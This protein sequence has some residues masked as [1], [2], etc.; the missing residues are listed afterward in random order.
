MFNIT[1]E[2]TKVRNINV[3]IIKCIAVFLVVSVH[4]FLN[5]GF[6]KTTIS[7]P[8][9]YVMVCI[10]TFSMMCVPLFLLI[11]GFLMNKKEFSKKFYFGLKR[12]LI[13]YTIISLFTLIIRVLLRD[14][15]FFKDVNYFTGFLDFNL[16]GYAWYVDM[17]IGLFLLIPFINKMFSDKFKDTVL[18][19]TLL[20][21]TMLPSICSGPTFFIKNWETIWPLTYYVFGAYV[22]RYNLKLKTKNLLLMFIFFMS[23]FIILNCIIT[24]N[25]L[26]N[27]HSFDSW[28]GLENVITSTLFFILILNLRFNISEKFK[29]VIS[30]I[31][32]L[33]LGIY[34]SSFIF[35]SIYYYFLNTNISDVTAKLNMYPVIVPASF[36]SAVILAIITDYIYKLIDNYIFKNKKNMPKI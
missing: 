10:R 4:F 3:D 35:D 32:N 31:A 1:D 19:C 18:L 5:N 21:L 14:Y 2:S 11:T 22:S 16:I 30:Y 34:L 13:P 9:M 15:S 25:K 36:L 29:K 26:W 6:Y 8:R 33:S 27:L 23:F 7:C 17:Y 12:I 20:F 28:G 24:H